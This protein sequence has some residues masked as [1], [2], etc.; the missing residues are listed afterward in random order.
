MIYLDSYDE[1]ED[2]SKNDRITYPTDYAIMNY[3]LMSRSNQGPKDRKSCWTWLRSAYSSNKV[4]MLKLDD[5]LKYYAV[6]NTDGGLCPTLHLNLSSVISQRKSS[7]DFFKISEIKNK[8]SSKYHTIE[9]GEYPK[10][11]VGDT[12]NKELERLYSSKKLSLTG[13]TYTGRIDND[14]EITFHSEFEYEGQKYVR[15]LTKKY[16]Y[17]SKYS[18]GTMAPEDGTYMWVKVEPIVWK[19]KELG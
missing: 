7:R 13:K 12:K 6:D 18:D 14:G 3:A 9:F 5:G 19:N 15:V 11:Y 8:D 17:D 16:D 10:T 2:V 1:V 4:Y